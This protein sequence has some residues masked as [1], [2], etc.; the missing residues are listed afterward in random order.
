MN[1]T[2]NKDSF[3]PDIWYFTYDGLEIDSATI[4]YGDGEST[5]VFPPRGQMTHQYNSSG[6]F[7][8]KILD[9]KKT[10]ASADIKIKV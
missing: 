7:T 10:L 2:A 8:I 3:H 5:N 1:L 4:D 9:G 6:S